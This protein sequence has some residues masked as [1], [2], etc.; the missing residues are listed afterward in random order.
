MDQKMMLLLHKY[1]LGITCRYP[2]CQSMKYTRC[3]LYL[4]IRHCMSYSC[5]HL[6]D[7]KYDAFQDYVEVTLRNLML[8]SVKEWFA[9]L[10]SRVE[11]GLQEHLNIIGYLHLLLIFTCYSVYIQLIYNLIFQ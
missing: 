2:D 4:K 8:Q 10:N 7:L 5:K 1:S 9:F 11:I 6:P 3:T